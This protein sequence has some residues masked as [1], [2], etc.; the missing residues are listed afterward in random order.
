MAILHEGALLSSV[1]RLSYN[2]EK[3]ERKGLEVQSE[4]NYCCGPTKDP[5]LIQDPAFIFVIML[6]PSATKQDQ[7]FIRDQL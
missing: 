2:W 3:K 1:Q 6:F 5:A 4:Y 7:A